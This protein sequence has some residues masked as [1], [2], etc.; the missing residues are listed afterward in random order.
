MEPLGYGLRT[1]K[2]CFFKVPY[3][4]FHTSPSKVL[5]GAVGV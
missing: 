3:Y 4:D 5:E 1:S 2:T